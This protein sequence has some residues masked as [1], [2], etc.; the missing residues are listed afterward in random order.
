VTYYAILDTNAGLLQWAGSAES[1]N[2][3]LAKW[4]AEV[5]GETNFDSLRAYRLDTRAQYR[6]VLKWWDNGGKS[7][8]TP[9]CIR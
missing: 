5:G 9:D 6:A 3:A 8:E 4:A 2:A 1:E 7:S